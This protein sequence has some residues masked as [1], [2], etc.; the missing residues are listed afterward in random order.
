MYQKNVL[1]YLQIIQI[2]LVQ[3]KT[4][5][6]ECYLQYVTEAEKMVCSI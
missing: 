5:E 4:L 2:Y 6:L 3:E 1:L